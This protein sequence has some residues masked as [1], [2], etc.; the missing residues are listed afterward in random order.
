[1][2]KLLA[3]SPSHHSIQDGNGKCFGIG[4]YWLMT[5]Q[6]D[7]E[8][9]TCL[10]NLITDRYDPSLPNFIHPSLYPTIGIHSEVVFGPFTPGTLKEGCGKL[11][12]EASLMITSEFCVLGETRVHSFPANVT[13]D[14]IWVYLDQTCEDPLQFD[15]DSIALDVVA[16]DIRPVGYPD[17]TRI[18]FSL[19]TF[20]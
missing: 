2:F 19:I 7:N 10:H 1:M 8:Q 15:R 3:L 11:P 4:L 12:I 17:P 5:S 6:V 16:Y 18:W 9:A 13:P 14:Q 20:S